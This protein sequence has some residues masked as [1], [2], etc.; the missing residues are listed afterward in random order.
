MHPDEP[1]VPA[2]GPETPPGPDDEQERLARLANLLFQ[3]ARNGDAA[4]LHEATS[5][6]APP[7]LANQNGDTLLMLAA[8]HG[9]EPAVRVLLQAGASVDQLNDRGQTPLGGATFKGFGDVVQTLLEF[10]ADPQ[11]GSPP[12]ISVAVMFSRDDLLPLFDAR[13]SGGNS[14]ERTEN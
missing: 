3:A 1:A 14:S 13:S 7:D 5:G 10:G 6:G 2:D 11:A 8:Y 4:L 9:H 12:A